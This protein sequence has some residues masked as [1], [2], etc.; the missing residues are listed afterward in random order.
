MKASLR[1]LAAAA[2]AL[3]V[4]FSTLTASADGSGSAP[5]GAYAPPGSAP[6]GAYAPP[7]AHAPPPDELR[8]RGE[9]GG[10][11]TISPGLA[12]RARNPAVQ[13]SPGLSF[14]VGRTVRYHLSVGYSHMSFQGGSLNGL[15]VRP[16]GIGIPIHLMSTPD[17][18]FAI[19]PLIDIIGVQGYFGGGAAAFMFSS[20][21]G[22]QA[23]MNFKHAY[24]SIAPLN[25]Q[26]Q[27]LGVAG[28]GGMTLSGADF[29]LNM[30]IRLS[31]GLRF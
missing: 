10:Y 18:A 11:F 26:F 17:F 13:I 20:G 3:A 24:V 15:D 23:I 14:A 9:F 27:Y 2:G 4:L 19:E 21:V 30:P 22:V 12:G 1:V 7:G 16:A 29:G 25:L 28:G 31:G 6:P 5:P 8:S